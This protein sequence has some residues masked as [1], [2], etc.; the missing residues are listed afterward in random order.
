MASFR[1]FWGNL[2]AKAPTQIKV[3]RTRAEN[4]RMSWRTARLEVRSS[5]EKGIT[6]SELRERMIRDLKLAGLDEG[7]RGSYSYT[8]ASITLP[9]L[10]GMGRPAGSCTGVSAG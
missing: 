5:Y 3:A 6:M 9:R 1:R 2:P 10:M 7:T 8:I 4:Y